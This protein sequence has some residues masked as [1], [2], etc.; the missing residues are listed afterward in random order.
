MRFRNISYGP[1]HWID[2]GAQHKVLLA[3]T[4]LL[5]GSTAWLMYMDQNLVSSAAPNGIV[6]FELAGSLQRSEAIIQSW[7]DQARSAALL[8]QGFDYLY[9]FIYPA[10]FSLAS[11][12]LGV[13]LGGRWQSA[14]LVVGWIVLFAAP[15]DAL[16]NYALI[17]QL[18]HGAGAATAKLALWCAIAKFAA[19]AVSAVFLLLAMGVWT[20]RSMFRDAA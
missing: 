7:S 5:V 18:L 4:F 16:E 12:S 2:S 10:W 14:G 9:L 8:I 6:S 11:V 1:F 20:A 15:F 19:I 17:Q 13:R 3:L